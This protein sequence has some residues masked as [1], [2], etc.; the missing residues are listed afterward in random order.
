[1]GVTMK[2]GT[3]G[4]RNMS[5][6]IAPT[7]APQSQPILRTQTSTAHPGVAARGGPSGNRGGES[8]APMPTGG[9]IPAS[10]DIQDP[11]A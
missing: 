4:M 9:T 6:A 3:S 2:G 8:I 1:M 7:P 5:N 10:T 11:G